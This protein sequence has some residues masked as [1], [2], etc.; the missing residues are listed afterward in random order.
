M[1]SPTARFEGACAVVSGS[2]LIALTGLGR[3][4]ES[5]GAGIRAT[6]HRLIACDENSCR[7]VFELPYWW[8]PYA[9]VCK[10]AASNMAQLLKS[11]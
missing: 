2:G 11:K 4:A 5:V 3:L 1:P 6:G 9:P 10:R 7:V 8:L